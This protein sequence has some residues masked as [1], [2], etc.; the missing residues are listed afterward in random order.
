MV[1]PNERE[2]LMDIRD[3]LLGG[4][5]SSVTLTATTASIAAGG[6]LKVNIDLGTANKLSIK[7]VKVVAVAST[8]FDIL[9]YPK[10]TCASKYEDYANENNNL[11]MNDLFTEPLNYEDEDASNELHMHI[12]NTDAVNASVFT[13]FVYCTK[14]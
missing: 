2:L 6:N 8:D 7:R 11:K 3:L 4:G 1:V 14:V 12:I 10:D 13:Y 9:F 5:S